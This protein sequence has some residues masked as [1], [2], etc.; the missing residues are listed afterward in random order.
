MSREERLNE[1]DLF[2]SG[3]EKKPLR[4]MIE[5]VDGIEEKRYKTQQ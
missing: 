3:V 5:I 1:I 4:V 2:I